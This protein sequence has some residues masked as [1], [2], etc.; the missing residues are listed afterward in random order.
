MD[1][2]SEHVWKYKRTAKT[3]VT[4]MFRTN[5]IWV[6]GRCRTLFKT[7]L[8]ETTSLTGLKR[9]DGVTAGP[10]PVADVMELLQSG[11]KASFRHMKAI[12]EWQEQLDQE[13]AG[14]TQELKR[15][16]ERAES[17]ADLDSALLTSTQT[18][19]LQSGNTGAAKAL[20]H[21]IHRPEQFQTAKS[22][23][24]E[25]LHPGGAT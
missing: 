18:Q 9:K 14:A 20:S 13:L 17:L 4:L 10:I 3:R 22:L 15:E 5:D 8:A 21:I 7:R 23:L 1:D 2:D 11:T 12:R 16:L 19:L 6:S 24:L 25:A